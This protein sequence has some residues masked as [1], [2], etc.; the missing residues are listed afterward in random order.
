MRPSAAVRWNHAR[1]QLV[2]RRK[3]AVESS[4]S[5]YLADGRRCPAP[6]RVRRPALAFVRAYCEALGVGAEAL[7]E[8]GGVEA[9]FFEGV[10]VGAVL[11]FWVGREEPLHCGACFLGER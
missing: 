4:A 11:V 9:E 6:F 1:S 2:M 3:G 10:A 7:A 5:R 8:R